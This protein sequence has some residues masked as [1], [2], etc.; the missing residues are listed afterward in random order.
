M[1]VQADGFVAHPP[2]AQRGMRGVKPPLACITT[3]V[4]KKEGFV[5]HTNINDT[6]T[7]RTLGRGGAGGVVISSPKHFICAA[8]GKVRVL[9]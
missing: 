6:I 2:H 4:S 7:E 5:R 3:I 9:L 8:Q 1:S